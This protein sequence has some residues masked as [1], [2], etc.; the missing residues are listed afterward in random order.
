MTAYPETREFF[1]SRLHQSLLGPGSD[2]YL[3]PAATEVLDDFPLQRYYTGILFPDREAEVTPGEEAERL[4]RNEAA[5]DLPH[6]ASADAVFGT[7][8]HAEAGFAPGVAP[9]AASAGEAAESRDE[10]AAA[11]HYFPSSLGLTC[12]VPA[13][14]PV[15]LITV[16]GASYRP[17]QAGTDALAVTLAPNEW[18]RLRPALSDGLHRKLSYDE[19]SAALALL[20]APEGTSRRPRTRDYAEVD[21]LG[22]RSHALHGSPGVAALEKLLRPAARLWQ[23]VPFEWQFAADLRPMEP[24]SEK[25]YEV[26]ADGPTGMVCW[27]KAYTVAPDPARLADPARRYVKVLVHN[28]AERHPARQFSNAN[29]HLNAK[30]RFQVELMAA[31]PDGVPL[32]P[33]KPDRTH[34][35][36]GDQEAAILNY[37]YRDC[38]A[39]GI[40][41]G[42]AV[43]WPA[44]PEGAR[45]RPSAPHFSPPWMCP[46]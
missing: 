21:R 6:D 19:A 27:V 45:L 43:C 44:P 24:K 22:S 25:K 17:W 3:G 30:C 31:L 9:A 35:L 20:A 7:E 15:L 18:E 38:L 14:A 26:P 37:Q 23:R 28:A 8:N 36:T 33:Y 13:E 34:T 42:A 41:H 46:A 11:N 5:D 1:T 10:Y 4:T 12:C 29:E 16:R 2:M 32:L 39:Y 40:G